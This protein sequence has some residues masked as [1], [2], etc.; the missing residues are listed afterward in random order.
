[1]TKCSNNGIE[2]AT[3][4]VTTIA[5]GDGPIIEVNQLCG[6]VQDISQE[7]DAFRYP[8]TK[9]KTFSGFVM[10]REGVVRRAEAEIGNMIMG[11]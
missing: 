6:S 9:K 11:G 1:M 2:S 7:I 8:V 4:N 5:K 10:R 3:I